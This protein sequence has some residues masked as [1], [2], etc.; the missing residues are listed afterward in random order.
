M[1]ATETQIEIDLVQSITCVDIKVVKTEKQPTSAD[2]WHLRIEGRFGDPEEDDVEFAGMGF[3]YA[4]G[5]LSFADARPRGISDMDFV[6]TDE[7]SAADMLRHFRYER[8]ELR[9]DADY[10]RGRC[11]KTEID[12]RSDGTFTLQTTNRGEAA[13]RWIGRLQGKKVL[14][15]VVDSVSANDNEDT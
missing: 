15:P 5:L 10:V 9:F 14:A 1:P 3:I 2:D 7:W 6:S 8:G 4:I 12:V 13:T 11:V